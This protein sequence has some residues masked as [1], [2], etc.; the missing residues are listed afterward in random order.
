M[1][2]WMTL[3]LALC[4]ALTLA[5]CSGDAAPQQSQGVEVDV[6]LTQLSSTLVYAEVY[7]MS[8]KPQDYAGKTVRMQGNLVYQVVNGQPSP[9]YMACLISDA[10]ACCAQGIEFV[11]AQPLEDY[12]E[13]GSMVTVTGVL[14]SYQSGEI[15]VLQLKE[16]TLEETA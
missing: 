10:T 2:K 6:D 7:N 15:N 16:A 4:L 14:S 13:L 12:P 1:K 9:D 5:A 11:L 8:I 3:L